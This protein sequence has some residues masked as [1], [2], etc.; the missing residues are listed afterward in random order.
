VE[1]LA[2]FFR[3]LKSLGTKLEAVALD[4]WKPYAR[5]IRL[6]YRR[7][8]LVYDVFHILADYSRVID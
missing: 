2:P 6:S 5:A 8:P 7:V 3:R 4:M 1:S